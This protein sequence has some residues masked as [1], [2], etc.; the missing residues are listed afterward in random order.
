MS[1]NYLDIWLKTSRDEK[2]TIFNE[3]AKR[4]GLPSWVIE[5]DWWVAFTIRTVFNMDVAPSILFKGGTS[6]SKAWQVIER[7]SEDI[8]LALDKS[9]LG[10]DVNM[11]KALV[12]KL[13]R[14]SFKYIAESFF[15]E[16]RKK[17]IESGFDDIDIHLIDIQS[18]DQDPLMI[19]I[20]YKSIIGESAYIKPRVL[21]EI[22]SR[23]LREPFTDRNIVS[24][25]GEHLNDMPFSDP[26]FKV[27]TVTPD[28][29]FLEKVF[30]LH[31]EFQKPFDKIRVDRLSRH[32][33]DIEKLIDTEFS[34]QALN[35]QN[36][37]ET[38]VEHRKII[39][40]IKGIDYSKHSPSNIIIVPP[41]EVLSAWKDDYEIM[42]ENMIY[43]E[44]LSF[45][46]LMQRIQA[47]QDRFHNIHWH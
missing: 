35:D 25:V 37:Y 44:S 36:L 1:E 47:L 34:K 19:E 9:F 17:F 11:N 46:I 15:P 20:I 30:L 4:N 10:F 13:R 41:G 28:R 32:L 31:E 2:F 43:G 5:K 18:T 7:F 29:T 3:V 45:D 38:I 39:N 33:Y 14:A 27:P 8:D 21:V 26:V 22:G 40:P 24:F 42:R 23:S 12:K 6:L 16:L